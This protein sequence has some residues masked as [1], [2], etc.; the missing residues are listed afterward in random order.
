[1]HYTYH[2]KQEERVHDL[3]IGRNTMDYSLYNSDL[4]TNLAAHHY[5]Q[6][7]KREY[8]TCRSGETQ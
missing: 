7:K 6:S 5:S 1:M 8:T 3:L 4:T 2:I